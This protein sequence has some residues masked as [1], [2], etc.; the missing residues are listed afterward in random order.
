MEKVN[1]LTDW[2][3]EPSLSDLKAD[4]TSCKPSHDSQIARINKWIELL[5]VSGS[6]KIE[7]VVFRQ[8]KMGQFMT[9]SPSFLVQFFPAQLHIEF[10]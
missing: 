9:Q 6:E 2:E 5:E 1:K 3:N 7:T 8:P 4:F 10:S